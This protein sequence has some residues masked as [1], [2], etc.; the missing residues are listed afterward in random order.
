MKEAFKIVA[1]LF[2]AGVIAELGM[3]A[4]SWS[5]PSPPTSVEVIHKVDD[6]ST[7]LREKGGA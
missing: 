3:R 5:I 2:L 7:C 1:L 6:G 4:A